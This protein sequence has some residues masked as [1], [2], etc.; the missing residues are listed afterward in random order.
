MGPGMCMF[1]SS[2][3]NSAPQLTLLQGLHCLEGYLGISRTSQIIPSLTHCLTFH[4][5][6]VLLGMLLLLPVSYSPCREG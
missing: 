5:L 1:I 4:S 6:R 3:A 2:P